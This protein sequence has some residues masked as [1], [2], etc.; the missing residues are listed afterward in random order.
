MSDSVPDRIREQIDMPELPKI[1]PE[2][3]REILAER[4]H[5]PDGALAS[6]R[7]LESRCPGWHCWWS[8]RPWR[9]DGDVPDGPAFGASRTGAG[10]MDSL[11]AVTPGE[12]AEKIRAAEEEHRALHPWRYRY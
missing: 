6:C 9:R 2:R 11:Y 12:L 1:D 3:N 7:Q 4:G 10:L 5:W 8:E